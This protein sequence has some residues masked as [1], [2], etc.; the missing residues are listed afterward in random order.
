MR[1]LYLILIALSNLVTARFNPIVLV[2]GALIIPV[3]SVFAGAVFVLRDLVQMK[4]GKRKTYIM[5]SLATILSALTSFLIGDTVHIAISSIMAFFISELVDTEIFSR[6]KRPLPVR[7][8][9]SGVVGGCL[10]SVVFVILGMSPLGA[11]ILMWDAVPFA[12]LGQMLTKAVVQ[13]FALVYLMILKN[14][15][16]MSDGRKKN[17]RKN[18]N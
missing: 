18:N 6:V 5:I 3:G 11:N 16:R 7:V 2:N 1:C 15:R 14:K 13:T 17:V 9:F 12:I 4:H 8:F 10:D